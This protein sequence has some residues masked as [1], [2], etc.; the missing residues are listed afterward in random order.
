MRATL[1]HFEMP[2]AD[3]ERLAAFLEAVFGWQRESSSPGYLRLAAAEA[4]R[5][6][7]EPPMRV[8]LYE[9]P[10]ATLDRAMPVVR[11]AGETLELCLARAREHGGQVLCAPQP[12]GASGRFARFEDPEGNPWGIWEPS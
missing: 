9:G 5:G 6:A 7:T 8:G 12:V 11:L 3:A 10:A 2:V 1:D 4:A